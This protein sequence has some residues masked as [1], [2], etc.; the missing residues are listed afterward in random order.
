MRYTEE[1]NQDVR[2]IPAGETWVGVI[3]EPRPHVAVATQLEEDDEGTLTLIARLSAGE[4]HQMGTE[5][6]RLARSLEAHHN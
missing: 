2:N 3:S 4:A 5:L 6:I 1:P